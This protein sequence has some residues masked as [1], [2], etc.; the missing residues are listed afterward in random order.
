MDIEIILV[1]DGHADTQ[2]TT[3]LDCRRL[4]A[5]TLDVRSWLTSHVVNS[6]LAELAASQGPGIVS[7]DLD[8]G[9]R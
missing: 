8:L 3:R 2:R 1:G 7:M 6:C 5:G 4:P 9:S